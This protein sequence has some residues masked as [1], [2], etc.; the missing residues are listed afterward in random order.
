MNP[1]G[2]IVLIEDDADE[3]DILRELC[4]RAS[5]GTE[6]IQINDSRDALRILKQCESPFMIFS[7]INLKVLNGFQLRKAILADSFLAQKCTPYIFYSAGSNELMLKRVH[8]ARADGY[9]YNISDYERL[10]EVISGII[11]H[12]SH[13]N[14]YF[15]EMRA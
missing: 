14:N 3:A 12:W 13:K 7:S 2:P 6:V 4:H 8:E 5:P 11:G 10:H 15:Y 9:F 1:N